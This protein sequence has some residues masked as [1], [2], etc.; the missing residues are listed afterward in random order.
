MTA[1]QLPDTASPS[2]LEVDLAAL[3]KVSLHDH[4]DGGLRV[5]TVLELA[6]EAGVELVAARLEA[7]PVVDLLVNNAG[8]G[9]AAPL[10]QADPDEM[11][12]MIGVNVTA[13]TRLAYAAAPAF[14]FDRTIAYES[15]GRP[16]NSAALAQNSFA[17]AAS[18]FPRYAWQIR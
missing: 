6:T 9:S 15:C 10:L 16:L 11:E 14:A 13:V 17:F 8:F 12:R 4:L 5:G 3:P 7:E 1:T 18:P 2:P